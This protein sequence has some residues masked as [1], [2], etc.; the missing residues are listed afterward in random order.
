MWLA[1]SASCA[2][3]SC[4]HSTADITS[5]PLPEKEKEIVEIER[6]N[7]Y[8]RGFGTVLSGRKLKLFGL[9]RRF[10]QGKERIWGTDRET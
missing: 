1:C 9:D 7:N 2:A 3:N 5:G 8:L 10:I 6:I 4:T